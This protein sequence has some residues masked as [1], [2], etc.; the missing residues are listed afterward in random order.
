MTIDGFAAVGIGAY[1]LLNI[2][3]EDLKGET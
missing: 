2:H 3:W 1:Q